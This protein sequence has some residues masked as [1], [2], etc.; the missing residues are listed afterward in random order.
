[1]IALWVVVAALTVLSLAEAVAIVALAR[2]VGLLAA[3]LPP[4]PALESGDGPPIGSAL[5]PLA[6]AALDGGGAVRL[7]GPTDRRR[8]LLFL[9]AQCAT[10]DTVLT[11]LPAVEQDWP[12]HEFVPIVSGPKTAVLAM[13]RRCRYA[14]RVLHGSG[15]TMTAVGISVT[16]SALVVDQRGTVTAQG[17]VNSREMVSSLLTGRVRVN[18]SLVG[19]HVRPGA[20][21]GRS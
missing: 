6:A 8:V 15:D 3:R 16:P 19:G 13:V 21:G 20:D 1:M 18:H 10:C 5:P 9:S 7:D 12:D 4:V 11:E 14:G 17:V 2:E